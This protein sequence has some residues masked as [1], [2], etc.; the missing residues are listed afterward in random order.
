M[1]ILSLQHI[2][3]LKINHQ[4]PLLYFLSLSLYLDFVQLRINAHR[5]DMFLVRA[6][7]VYATLQPRQR[8]GRY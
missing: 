4:L 8:S 3:I 2:V 1:F 7:C 5:L 6:E